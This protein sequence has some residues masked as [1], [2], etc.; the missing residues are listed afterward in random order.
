MKKALLAL[1]ALLTLFGSG[2]LQASIYEAAFQR[3]GITTNKAYPG[4]GHVDAFG[5]DVIMNF[6]TGDV[7]FSIKNQSGSYIAAAGTA[8][9]TTTRTNSYEF[10]LADGCKVKSIK[11]GCDDSSDFYYCQ[12]TITVETN[13]GDSNTVA[14]TWTNDGVS[15]MTWTPTNAMP[16]GTVK[17]TGLNGAYVYYFLIEYEKEDDEV[18]DESK[19]V[20]HCATQ[21]QFGSQYYYAGNAA[22]TVTWPLK[23][24]IKGESEAVS[25]NYT[26]STGITYS[27]YAYDAIP[28]G[29][30]NILKFAPK[31]GYKLTK[32]TFGVGDEGAQD[33]FIN[34][35]YEGGQ[36]EKQ[37][38]SELVWTGEATE[39]ID[40]T[41]NSGSNVMFYYEVEFAPYEPV[42]PVDE[43]PLLIVIGK[44]KEAS[45]EAL[46]EGDKVTFTFQKEDKS[47]YNL[48]YGVDFKIY[49]DNVL[50]GYYDSTS[51]Q[52]VGYEESWSPT[53]YT[54]ASPYQ[55]S[56]DYNNVKDAKSIRIEVGTDYF[57]NES[58]FVYTLNIEGSGN[59]DPVVEDKEVVLQ[60]ATPYQPY[61]TYFYSGD[62]EIQ[63]WTTK[64]VET[65]N[66]AFSFTV[67]DENGF[68][69][70]D[71]SNGVF[72]LKNGFKVVVTPKEGYQINSVSF[73]TA[74]GDNILKNMTCNAGGEFASAGDKLVQWTGKSKSATE[75]VY[76]SSSADNMF[77]YIV[78][79]GAAEAEVEVPEADPFEIVIGNNKEV[80]V[81]A[82]PEG[83]EMTFT[84]T[85]NGNSFMLGQGNLAV[86]KNGTVIYDYST[87]GNLDDTSAREDGKWQFNVGEVYKVFVKTADFAKGDVL[88]INVDEGYFVGFGAFTYTL[89]LGEKEIVTDPESKNVFEV[90][91]DQNGKLQLDE[92]PE[93]GFIKLN[94]VNALNVAYTCP[95][96]TKA[97][98]G[99]GNLFDGFVGKLNGEVYYTFTNGIPANFTHAVTEPE[100]KQAFDCVDNKY[101]MQIP[102]DGLKLGDRI[103]LTFPWCYFRADSNTDEFTYIIQ[104]GES[105]V[106]ERDPGMTW[107]TY[108]STY[109]YVEGA[110]I[111]LADN[112][113]SNDLFY[114]DPDFFQGNITIEGDADVL[115]SYKLSG[116]YPAYRLTGKL[117][118]VT[119]TATPNDLEKY[120]PVTFTLHVIGNP[121]F[122]LKV[123]TPGA[124]YEVLA[125]GDFRWVN[126]KE[127]M[128]VVPS[129]YCADRSDFYYTINDGDEQFVD[130]DDYIITLPRVNGYYTLKFYVSQDIQDENPN[131]EFTPSE[132]TIGH[133]VSSNEMNHT[134]DFSSTTTTHGSL[135]VSNSLQDVKWLTDERSTAENEYATSGANFRMYIPYAQ[136]IAIWR[137]NGLMINQNQMF[138]IGFADHASTRRI[139][140]IVITGENIGNIM[141][142]KN[143]QATDDPRMTGGYEKVGDIE[144]SGNTLTWTYN[145]EETDLRDVEIWNGYAGASHVAARRA[146]AAVEV[147]PTVIKSVSFATDMPTEVTT[148]EAAEDAD[149]IYFDLQ[150]RQ[151][152][153]PAAGVYIRVAGGKSTKVIVK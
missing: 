18:L 72:T 15:V 150:G 97:E 47:D 56:F 66:D 61:I 102:T 75:F 1:V 79:Y 28:G 135:P 83:D 147:T 27:N 145:P 73:G 78:K 67:Y 101:W 7:K 10:V 9:I 31:E 8:Y 86:A 65:E 133:N 149:A 24:S 125:S 123:T 126:L 118:T 93:G 36:L 26:Y 115:E 49:L 131:V 59:E 21:N 153:N 63:S 58:S 71:N 68:K 106:D 152:E 114:Y 104:I 108:S 90:V 80:K 6:G 144:I 109:K 103:E 87:I 113:P 137:A 2:V 30:N 82:V 148:I 142:G 85:N 13:A 43:D 122:G 129:S 52:P 40:F 132:F 143:T 128:T 141:V 50:K 117:G 89:T 64:T 134:I 112:T 96:Y 3:T 92:I 20:F 12:G 29:K 60:N 34:M 57:K 138:R 116:Y 76:T 88:T 105:T 32:I 22:T 42:A 25:F 120:K 39:E 62:L 35:V 127:T 38:T 139:T 45:V 41:L 69:Y 110:E 14:G 19:V 151:I 100:G 23:G 119:V 98:W 46:P 95:A 84:F 130:N 17:I 4:N 53:G 146:A 140:K 54:E 37:G 77:Y 33:D 121:A 99:G 81:D 74:G 48:G 51:Y 5:S 70:S 44:D 55:I 11:C 91:M 16:D 94:F 136:A 124:G 107:K 111:T